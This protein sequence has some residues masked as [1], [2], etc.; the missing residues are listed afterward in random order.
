MEEPPIVKIKQGQLRGT[1]G[2]DFHGGKFYCYLGI[3]YAKPPVGE[4]RFKAPLPPDPWDGVRD[5][6]KD[7]N[8]CYSIDEC[9][10][11]AQG[12]EDCLFLNVFSC[13]KP[14]P[15]LVWIHGGGFIAGT[16]NSPYCGPEFLLTEHVVLVAMNY[17]L[18]ALGFLC[19][20]DTSLEVPGNAA[21]KDQTLALKWVQENIANFGGDPNN[22]TIFGESAGSASV[23][24]HVLSQASKGLFHKAILQS[25]YNKCGYDEKQM[26]EFLRSM[27][28]EKLHK[29]QMKV[30]DRFLPEEQRPFTPVIEKPNGA[31]FLTRSA[32]DIL[33]SGEYNK[34][35][36]IMGYN[37]REGIFLFLLHGIRE[38]LNVEENIPWQVKLAKGSEE[39]KRICKK[40]EDLYLKCGDKMEN[41]FVLGTDSY[42]L[43]GIF[44]SLKKHLTTT[45]MP[46]YFY[47]MSLDAKLNGGKNLFKVLRQFPGQNVNIFGTKTMLLNF[48][49]HLRHLPR[50][51]PRLPFETPLHPC[52]VPGSLEELSVKRFVKL[53]TNFARYGDP[54]PDPS[55]LGVTWPQVGEKMNLLD[56]GEEL[57]VEDD[58]E[59]ERMALWKEI[60]Q[61]NPETA[62]FLQHYQL[63]IASTVSMVLS[64]ALFVNILIA[65][66]HLVAPENVENPVVTVSNGRLK[67][68]TRT[69][70]DEESFFSFFGIP[71]AKPPVGKL[72]FKPPVAAESW[73]GIRDATK[74][75]EVCYARD[76]FDGNIIKG[77]EDCLFLNIYTKHVRKFSV[78]I[79]IVLVTL[80]YRLGVL[81]FLSL[82]DASLGVP[83]NMGLKDQLL[84][85]KWIQRNIASFNG[86]PNS[87]TIF[88][89]SSGAASVHYHILSRASKGLFHKTI[90]QSGEALYPFERG[91]HVGVEFAN[92]LGRNV[93]TEKEALE[94]LRAAPVN[95]LFENQ[96]KFLAATE[97]RGNPFCPIVEPPGDGAI[98]TRDAIDAIKSGDY[99]RVPM[100]IGY[101]NREGMLFDAV[102]AIGKRLSKNESAEDETK[103]EPGSKESILGYFQLE[104][105]SEIGERIYRRVREVYFKHGD[106]ADDDRVNHLVT[107]LEPIYVYRMSVTS[108]L[109]FMKNFAGITHIPGVCHADDLGYL[110]K[111]FITPQ[112]KRGSLEDVSFRRF[113][114]MWTNF[115]QYGNPTPNKSDAPIKQLAV[116]ST[117]NM[118]LSVVLFFDILIATVSLVAPENVEN[119]VV[120]V[121]NGRLRGSTRTNID[122]ESFFSFFGIPYAKPPVGNLRFKPPV[123]AESWKGIRDATKLGD[124]CYARDDFDGNIIKGSEDCLFLNIYTKHLPQPNK[125]LRP[126]MV[127]I[128]GGAFTT[129]SNDPSLYGPELLMI[130]DIV[131][132]TLNYRLGVLGFLSLEDA[133]LGVP[134]N[135]GL[136]DQLLALMWV[137]RNIASFNGD[138]KSVTIFGES[139]GA[140]SVHYHVLS[141]ASKGFFHKAIIQSGDALVSAARGFY[142]GV[143]FANYLDRNVSTEKEALQVLRTVPVDVLFENQEKFRRATAQRGNAFSPVVEPPGDGAI[144]TR[145]AIDSIKSGDYNKVPMLMGYNNRE[146]ML[147]DAVAAVVKRLSKNESTENATKPEPGSKESILGYFQLEE[148]SEIGE[149]IYRRVREVYFKHADKADDNRVLTTDIYFVATIISAVKNHLETCQE[150]I[151]VYRMSV[152]S[153]LNFMKNVAGIT[154]IPGVCHADDLGYLF[155][156]FITP[157]IKRGS[158]EDVSFRRFVK[159]WT[160]F[161]KYGNPTPNKNDVGVIWKP[162]Q[163]GNINFLD[164]GSELT[165][166]ANPESERSLY[167]MASDQVNIDASKIQGFCFILFNIKYLSTHVLN[168]MEN[169][170]VTVSQGQLRGCS[171]SDIDGNNFFSFLG[172]PYARPPV[173][174]L[175]FKPP[176]PAEPWKGVRDALEPGN[177]CYSRDDISRVLE[178]SEDCLYL[179]VF[180][181][182][183]PQSNKRLRPV[184]VWIHGGGFV[185]GSSKPALYGP[186]FLMIEDIVLV[187]LNY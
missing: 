97:A 170:T 130:E 51:R 143:E 132:V 181:K 104:E 131:L 47:R 52:V 81:G 7:G 64:L 35:P 13:Q 78:R 39:S 46:I 93:S 141:R 168:N 15:V 140:A 115:A 102:E 28:V 38:S 32:I 73:K 2:T 10:G 69:N 107:C 150:P 31:A 87:V 9:T 95:V 16:G 90:L 135:M 22:V 53:W 11:I 72:R 44:S 124:V 21:L 79:N 166:G 92:Y 20:E 167:F 48:Y 114:K 82:E 180:T 157:Q 66:V 185:F 80:N 128:H 125:K 71:F 145:D 110:F 88:G 139:S 41:Q 58:V 76:D 142:V 14:K 99:N 147:I 84:A 68:N 156:N 63:A 65:T 120:T 60:Y 163:R 61:C 105:G 98:I 17:R 112:I 62:N 133:S 43:A 175:R 37:K 177:R 161:A 5:A 126:V 19:L 29:A 75:G 59:P 184:M 117:V 160:N 155:K 89:E 176:L 18:G 165:T 36:M 127:W 83:G 67:G 56:I 8:R 173:G 153:G 152:T 129:G 49:F 187:T 158:L 74:P 172:I 3:P 179:N 122:G 144:V 137:Q 50:G 101:N 70:V 134:G 121:S 42:F 1:V 100:L 91:F 4:L 154:E 113:V 94:V 26:L 12:S 6:T 136:K 118:V 106:K 109:N 30:P 178:G 45:K 138:P 24:L 77:S 111:N 27:P 85:L 149:R 171:T 33:T 25:G 103:P 55:E 186:E 108:G 159:M 54:T 148:G 123:A 169:P 146:G 182:E 151:Y 116:A 40:M 23:H 96:E 119:P 34:V 86:D 174:E 164:I 162:A 183:L 57:S